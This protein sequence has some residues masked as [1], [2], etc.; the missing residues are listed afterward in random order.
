MRKSI[1]SRAIADSKNYDQL[2]P[3]P[4][5]QHSSFE[6]QERSR[7]IFRTMLHLWVAP[8]LDHGSTLWLLS[9]GI[10]RDSSPLDTTWCTM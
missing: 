10:D 3:S 1:E 5:S 4:F 8:A 2:S 6:M 7:V 9:Q